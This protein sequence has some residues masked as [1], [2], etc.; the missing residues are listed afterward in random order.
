[1]LGTPRNTEI[2]NLQITSV[3]HLADGYLPLSRGFW[4]S[5]ALW[6]LGDALESP[7]LDKPMPHGL[8]RLNVASM[9]L[10]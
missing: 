7:L 5:G 9:Y 10:G 4:S 6:K 8:L 3:S 1:M 2:G